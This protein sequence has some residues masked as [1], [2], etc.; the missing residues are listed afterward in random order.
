MHGLS[1]TAFSMKGFV[2][3]IESAIWY[4][5]VATRCFSVFLSATP[6]EKKKLAARD[7]GFHEQCSAIDCAIADF[8]A[9]AGA[10]SQR[11]DFF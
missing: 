11:I 6:R 7:E 5:R 4:A 2:A 1:I 8:P 10:C 9:P 3:G